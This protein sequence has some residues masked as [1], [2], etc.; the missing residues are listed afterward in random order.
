MTTVEI[1][2]D[3]LWRKAIKARD[4]HCMMCGAMQYLE[5]HHALV[6]R[7]ATATRWAM[8][9]GLALCFKC[10]AAVHAGHLRDKIQAALDTLDTR[11]AQEALVRLGHTCFKA[12]AEWYK[13]VEARLVRAIEENDG[14]E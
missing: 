2:L 1:K 14:W 3:G 11:A 12:T 5:A 7:S 9:N 8:L 10:H 4:G 6:R 13:A